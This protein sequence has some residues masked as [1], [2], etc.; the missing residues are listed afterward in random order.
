MQWMGLHRSPDSAMTQEKM[1]D[2]RSKLNRDFENFR[3]DGIFGV[4][5]QPVKVRDS[6]DFIW[7]V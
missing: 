7:E 5:M 2:F 6:P 1:T 3:S 4:V